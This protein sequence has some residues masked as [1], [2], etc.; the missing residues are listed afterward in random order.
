[1]KRQAHFVAKVRVDPL[2][3]LSVRS[4]YRCLLDM[5]I[6]GMM[7]D[8]ELLFSG[9]TIAPGDE[10]MVDVALL[11]PSFQIGRLYSGFRF[12]IHEGTVKVGDGEITQVLESE[13]MAR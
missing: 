11:V 8:G 5:G 7:N 2:K 1:M 12:T 9:G 13:L 10:G 6:E 4:G 3:R